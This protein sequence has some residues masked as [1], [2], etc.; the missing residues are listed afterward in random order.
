VQTKRI[1]TIANQKGGV[2]KTTTSVNLAAALSCH[3]KRV[4]LIDL[5]AQA[6]ATRWLT[7]VYGED[8]RVIYDVMLRRTNIAECIIKGA[9]GVDLVPSNLS[10]AT[11]DVDLLSEY[12]R[13]HRLASALDELPITYNYI[14]IDCP[15]NLAM[16]TIN[17][18]AAATAV[19][20]PIECKAESYEAVPRLMNTLRKA[21]TEFKKTIRI[22]AL[23][24]F[25]ERT[26]LARDI[27]EAIKEKFE[28]FCLSPIHKNNKLAEAFAARQPIIEYDPTANGAV[29]YMRVAKEL[30]DVEE[31]EV[32]QRL[33]GRKGR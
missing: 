12:N 15:P 26:N 9:S 7:G 8:G 22:Y 18:F 30:I 17:A 32:R 11:L 23:P 1:I 5:D 14:L 10:L 13:E 19:L 29:D 6:N 2:G 16:V 33:E 4:L 31:E 27:H 28:S 25:V 20:I 21:V 24:T 3:N